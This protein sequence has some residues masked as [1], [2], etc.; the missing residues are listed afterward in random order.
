MNLK[1]LYGEN[2]DLNFYQN[3]IE[4]ITDTFKENEGVLPNYLFSDV[5]EIKQI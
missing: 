4:K 1:L 2:A 5:L 3:R